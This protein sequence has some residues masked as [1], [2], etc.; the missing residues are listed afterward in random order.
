MGFVQDSSE[1][2]TVARSFY[3]LIKEKIVP[4]Y[5]AERIS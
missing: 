1:V 4:F 5:Q 2:V 3:M